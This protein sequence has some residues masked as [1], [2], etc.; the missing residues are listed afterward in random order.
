MAVHDSDGPDDG[1]SPIGVN[2][3]VWAVWYVAFYSFLVILLTKY[4]CHFSLVFT[5]GQL[6]TTMTAQ[7]EQMALLSGPLGMCFF[8][9]HPGFF[10][11]KIY[12]LFYL[13]LT[14]QQGGM[15]GKAS[16]KR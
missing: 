12:L 8:L 10:T 15:L 11:N 16:E 9:I 4:I 5:F 6:S 7:T 14:L 2:G 3:T 1:D 13:G